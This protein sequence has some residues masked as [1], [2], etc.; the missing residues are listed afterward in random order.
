MHRG[1]FIHATP[2][3]GCDCID[4]FWVLSR[5]DGYESGRCCRLEKIRKYR[6]HLIRRNRRKGLQDPRN[7]RTQLRDRVPAAL[8][9]RPEIMGAGRMC[10]PRRTLSF[11]HSHQDHPICFQITKR[12]IAGEYLCSR[13][14]SKWKPHTKQAALYLDHDHSKRVNI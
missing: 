3:A 4:M 2:A 7:I 12:N 14:N 13:R 11:Q 8:D 1:P 5:E 10:R 6:D 9:Q